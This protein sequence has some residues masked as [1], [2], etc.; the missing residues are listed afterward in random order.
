MIDFHGG[1]L[2]G[3]AADQPV[4]ADLEVSHGRVRHLQ[5]QPLPAQSGWRASFRLEPEGRQPADMR[6]RLSLYG[7][8]IS[9]TW[10]HVWYP[11]QAR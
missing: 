7:E 8:T 5:T 2:E 10:N 9:E 6:L 4:E 1:E 11:D 3:L